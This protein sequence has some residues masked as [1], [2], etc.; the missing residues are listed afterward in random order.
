MGIIQSGI[1]SKVSGKVAGV[2]GASWKDKAY[3]RAYVTPAN[4]NTVAQQAQ[5]TKFSQCVA[6]AKPL[7]GQV[8]QE[9]ID[10]F[11][12]KMSGFNYFVKSNIDQFPDPVSLLGIK[13]SEGPLSAVIIN[14]ATY[15]VTDITVTFYQNTGN[16]GQAGDKVFAVAYNEVNGIFY[17]A[18]AEVARSALSIIVPVGADYTATDF[19][20]WLITSRLVGGARTMVGLSVAANVSAP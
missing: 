11:Q 19:V 6:F 4:P 10:P 8:I 15:A 14:T 2:V 9:Y 12:K 13:L 7:L 1:L 17:F 5:R 18:S 3:L 20:V 16:N